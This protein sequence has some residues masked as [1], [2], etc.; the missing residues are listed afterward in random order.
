MAFEAKNLNN[1]AGSLGGPNIW[2]YKS[3]VDKKDTI[4]P[5]DGG[6]YFAEAQEKYGMQADDII[7][8]SA[9]GTGTGENVPQE[10]YWAQ[11]TK[12]LS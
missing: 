12:P 5:T 1:I 6:T 2:I 11:V 7:L 4:S 10:I 9:K 3:I 8:V